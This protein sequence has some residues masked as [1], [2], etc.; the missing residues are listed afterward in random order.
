MINRD[1]D[2]KIIV[3][4]YEKF[5]KKSNRTEPRPPLQA[6][7]VDGEN[8]NDNLDFLVVPQYGRNLDY[9]G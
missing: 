7:I 3:I 2:F 9:T 8:V 6:G 5:S 1:Y 4:D